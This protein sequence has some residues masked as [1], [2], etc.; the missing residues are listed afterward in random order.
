M[1]FLF[2]TILFFCLATAAMA[3]EIYGTISEAGKPIV[4]GIKVEVA[5]VGKTYSGDTD[6]FGTYHIAVAE[7][8]KGTLTAT[9]KDQKLSAD[10]FIYDKATRYDWTVETVDGKMMIKRK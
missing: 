3:G 6:K 9:Y 10:I 1:R 8:G 5:I 4:A 2:S 7:K